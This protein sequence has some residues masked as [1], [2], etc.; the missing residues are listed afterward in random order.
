MLPPDAVQLIIDLALWA[1]VVGC[2][3]GFVFSSLLDKLLGLV[4]YRLERRER[5][6]QARSRDHSKVAHI[7]WGA[8]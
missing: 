2:L 6:E 1:I 7:T 8:E 3:V 4:L 5:I